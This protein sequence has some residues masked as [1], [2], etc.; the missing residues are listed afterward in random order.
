MLSA[1]SNIKPTKRTDIIF[2]VVIIGGCITGVTTAY[3]LQQMGYKVIIVE[4]SEIGF[5]TSG[6]YITHVNNYYGS[7]YFDVIKKLDKQQIVQ[8]NKAGNEG[9][10]LILQLVKENN[11]DCDL[12]MAEGHLFAKNNM[13]NTELENIKQILTGLDK[14]KIGAKTFPYKMSR[15]ADAFTGNEYIINNVKYMTALKQLFLEAGGTVQERAR[16]LKVDNKQTK[17]V[18]T[19]RGKVKGRHLVYTPQTSRVINL[20]PYNFFPYIYYSVSAELEK[21]RHGR[22]FCYDMEDP[23]HRF[24][25]TNDS[26]DK[27]VICGE[28]HKNV[29]GRIRSDYFDK[30]I[31]MLKRNFKFSDTIL[32]W[33]YVYYKN[34]DGLPVIG[35][36]GD[37]NTFIAAGYKPDGMVLAAIGAKIITDLITTGSSKYE[38]VYKSSQ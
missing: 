19:T 2:D 21:G 23:S 7:V 25:V 4:F 24:I 30:L 15:K 37:D 22:G 18:F 38:S 14:N 36:T 27:V 20:K 13:E 29:K 17:T 6:S 10:K 11:I 1:K 32:T 33:S 26:L 5:F 9:T 28:D 35:P 31:K 34:K 12:C 16:V 3:L 8:H